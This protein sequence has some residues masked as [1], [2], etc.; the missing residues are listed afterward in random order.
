MN[1]AEPALSHPEPEPVGGKRK[2]PTRDASPRPAKQA[3]VRI[4]PLPAECWACVFGW[5]QADVWDVAPLGRLLLVSRDESWVA[6]IREVRGRNMRLLRQRANAL[7]LVEPFS[8]HVWCMLGTMYLN[9]LWCPAVVRTSVATILGHCLMAKI[10]SC[11]DSAHETPL[12]IK[13]GCPQAMQIG[14][15]ASL[16]TAY[17]LKFHYHSDSV[18]LGRWFHSDRPPCFVCP[19]FFSKP[20]DPMAKLIVRRIYAVLELLELNGLFFGY[21]PPPETP[22]DENSLPLSMPTFMIGRETPHC[23][24]Q[25]IVRMQKNAKP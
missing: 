14:V 25:T 20:G 22:Y 23:W 4:P 11:R 8:G 2:A 1:E 19:L 13:D 24:M 21:I 15:D 7:G 3:R 17:A 9:R 16:P 5:V 6:A 10:C 18:V 12:G